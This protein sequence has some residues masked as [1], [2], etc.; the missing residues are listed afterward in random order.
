MTYYQNHRARLLAIQ[1]EHYIKHGQEILR[2]AFERNVL[3]R[4]R[5]GLLSRQVPAGNSALKA[6]TQSENQD[7]SATHTDSSPELQAST[8]S[9]P[10]SA[11]YLSVQEV[12]TRY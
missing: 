2:K 3:R 6:T 10:G 7:Y 11:P 9:P 4:V 12:E 8:A 1:R 5:G